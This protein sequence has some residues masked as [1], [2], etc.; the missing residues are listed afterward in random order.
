MADI[1]ITD[2]VEHTAPDDADLLEAVDVSDSTMD[3]TGTNKR[4]TFLNL[5]TWLAGFFFGPTNRQTNITN[6]E[7]ANVD[8]Q[9]LQGRLAA[10]GAPQ[11]IGETDVPTGIPASGDSVLAWKA[12]GALVR[13]DPDD[14]GGPGGGGDVVQAGAGADQDV[15]FWSDFSVKEV[16]A[17]TLVNGGL[18]SKT[19]GTL[20]AIPQ[21]IGGQ[22]L[23]YDGVGAPGPGVTQTSSYGANTV[24]NTVLTDVASQTLK[25]RTS[26]GSGDPQDFLISSLTDVASPAGTEQL[27]AMDGGN[28]RRI[29]V[30]NLPTGGGG[31]V[32]ISTTPGTVGARDAD[33]NMAKSGSDLQKKVLGG[34]DG[35]IWTNGAD[36]ATAT[37]DI[38]PVSSSA[39][40]FFANALRVVRGQSIKADDGN[41]LTLVGDVTTPGTNRIYG[42]TST[43]GWY[44][45]AELGISGSG[46]VTGPGTHADNVLAVFNGT[47]SNAIDADGA[48][49]VAQVARLD[50]AANFTVSLAEQAVNVVQPAENLTSGATLAP[51][52]DAGNSPRLVHN[53]S[54]GT[55]SINNPTGQDGEAS[56][57]IYNATAL[58]TI[59]PTEE[60]TPRGTGP[61]IGYL[62]KNSQGSS[63]V[64]ATSA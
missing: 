60:N 39:L 59:Q 57:Y 45:A 43:R 47:N 27:L 48:V 51:N 46:D 50:Q 52:F 5:R 28:L 9:H 53:G 37:V 24:P 38:D 8:A 54:G 25:G 31:E 3:P 22:L 32:N 42:H 23:V 35:I 34:G 29:S 61:W 58:G 12:G 1:K 4:W 20:T 16:G 21:G 19:A 36:T 15:T 2:Y 44:T 55:V 49:P 41:G 18:V 7:R 30:G 40:G 11:D 10:A 17:I 62:T 64:W 14:L 26:A 6:A 33:V 56:I 13:F 63:I